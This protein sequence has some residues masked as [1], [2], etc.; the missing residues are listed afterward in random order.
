MPE[1]RVGACIVILFAL[2]TP[3]TF[4]AIVAGQDLRLVD[5]AASQDD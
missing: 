1:P 4:T 3:G 5:A 2:F